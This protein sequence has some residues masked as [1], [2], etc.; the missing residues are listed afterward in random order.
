MS[1]QLLAFQIDQQYVT[2]E[3]EIIFHELYSTDSRPVVTRDAAYRYVIE[4][5]STP[6][7]FNMEF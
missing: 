7:N 2:Y 4:G 3:N 6:V 1:I 5:R